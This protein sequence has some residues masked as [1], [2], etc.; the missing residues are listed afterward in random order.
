MVSSPVVDVDD[1]TAALG[2]AGRPGVGDEELLAALR[3]QAGLE[4]AV[5]RAM[6]DTVAELQRRGTF[7]ERGQRPTTALAD[8]LGLEPFEARL[9]VL[10]A[11]HVVPRVDL[12]GQVLPPR[13]PATAAA[14]TSGAASLRHV[15]AIA[16]LLNGPAAERLAAEV[17]AGAEEE[18][19]AHAGEF[20]PTELRAFGSRLL[21]MLDQDGAEPDDREPPETNELFL[22][23]HPNGSGGRIK[24]RIDN[25]AMFDVIAAVLDAR[26]ALLT[27]DDTRSRG[28]RQAE[29][30]ADVFGYVADH[31]DTEVLP[32]T[33]GR[34]PH[35][36][37]S[38]ECRA[39]FPTVFGEP[40]PRATAAA[41]TP[42]AIVRSRGLRFH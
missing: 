41:H 18:I 28:Q 39:P 21:D 29:A 22:T 11:E 9:L 23:R 34:R 14:F 6:V 42:V 35:V 7:A 8:L 10:A 30:M 37:V 31:G 33:G 19:A 4:R 17:R 20:T 27:M 38:D 24:G 36:T 1:V 2:V 26:S 32:T 12:Q 13:L 16:Q 3:S 25:A 15:Q 40:W 5:Q